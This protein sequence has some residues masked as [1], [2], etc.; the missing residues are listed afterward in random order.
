MNLIVLLSVIITPSAAG[1]LVITSCSSI[2]KHRKCPFVVFNI[3]NQPK[4]YYLFVIYK[5]MISYIKIQVQSD[6]AKLE[7]DEEIKNEKEEMGG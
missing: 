7:K 4:F 3:F 1:S 6:P 2:F 5:P